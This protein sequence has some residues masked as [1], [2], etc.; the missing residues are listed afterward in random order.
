MREARGTASRSIHA[1][2][3]LDVGEGMEQHTRRW[4]RF[5]LGCGLLVLVVWGAFVAATWNDPFHVFRRALADRS[6]HFGPSDEF[7]DRSIYIVGRLP[8]SRFAEMADLLE[9]ERRTDGSFPDD[10]SLIH[11]STDLKESWWVLPTRFDEL[12]YRADPGF[13]ELLGRSGD[14]VY[15]QSISW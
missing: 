9:L 8:E 2:D 6:E 4:I 5:A 1:V 15:Y 12:Y 14:K 7:G 11:W 13:Q 10:R 3:E